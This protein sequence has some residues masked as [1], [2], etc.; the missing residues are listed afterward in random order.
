M[1]KRWT[2]S[3]MIEAKKGMRR[4]RG[5]KSLPILQGVL[6]LTRLSALLPP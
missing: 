4:L 3:A 5:Y 1:V 2:V 6:Q